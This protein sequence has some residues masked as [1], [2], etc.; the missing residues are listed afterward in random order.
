MKMLRRVDSDA[1]VLLI[2]GGGDECIKLW[3]CISTSQG[4][5]LLDTFECNQRE[6]LS[7][8]AR[9]GTIYA[10]CRDGCVAV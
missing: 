8:V 9:D 7:L 6:V 2:T 4:P 10:G 5:V 1:N 3:N